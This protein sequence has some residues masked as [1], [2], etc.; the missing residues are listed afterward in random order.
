MGE[1]GRLYTVRQR[2]P[3]TELAGSFVGSLAVER[4]QRCRSARDA[5]N[6]RAPFVNTNAR[7]LYE[8]VA[9]VDFFCKPMFVH[10]VCA[11]GVDRQRN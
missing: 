8:V 2:Q 6:L 1:L 4:H 11:A 10:V 5:G 9:A 3:S 7:D